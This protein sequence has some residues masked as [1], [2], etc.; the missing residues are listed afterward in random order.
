MQEDQNDFL[1][2]QAGGMIQRV[3]KALGIRPPDAPGG[4]HPAGEK[5]PLS[6][7][8]KEALWRRIQGSMR[9][10]NDSR[11][12][13]PLSRGS[14]TSE[15]HAGGTLAGGSR[16]SSSRGKQR[17]I[18]LRVAAA[19]VLLAGTAAWLL[20]DREPVTPL[21]QMMAAARVADTVKTEEVQVVTSGPDET[22][23]ASK[24]PVYRT[25]VVPY[26]KRTVFFLP[27]SS[28]VWLNAGSALVYPEMFAGSER[29]VYLEGEAYFDVQHKAGK[30]FLVQTRDMEIK[31]LGTEFNVSAYPDDQHSDVVLVSGSIELSA[32]GDELMKKMRTRLVPHE[33]A[34]YRPSEKHLE[35]SDTQVDEYV[36][37]R[38]GSI[39]FKAAP[40]SEI[41]K[42]LERY[43][44]VS[45]ALEGAGLGA[46]TFTGPLDLKKEIDEV[47]D[48]ICFTTA[49]VY[50]KQ[51]G[52]IVLKE[53]K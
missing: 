14:A 37:W 51:D 38:T 48:I 2:S 16:K 50:E 19:V 35:V 39:T 36:S 7:A 31:V 46:E 45:I 11:I 27:D 17:V 22:E 20:T 41:L 10:T 47:M 24:Q 8:E 18:W 53:R 30:P 3:L 44:R 9:R 12:W 4:R 15:T 21:K 33:I 34:V 1:N 42:K 6:K 43:Y 26:G 49:L 25:L 29:Q 52:K 40:L 32:N 5:R 28:R 13:E 23:R